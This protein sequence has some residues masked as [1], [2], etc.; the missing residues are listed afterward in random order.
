M[1]LERYPKAVVLDLD[2]TLWPFWCDTHVVRPLKAVSDVV[3]ID[4]C[5]LELSFYEEVESILLELKEYDVKIIGAS[6][7]GTPDIAKDLLTMLHIRGNPA[8]TYFDCLEWGTGSKTRHIQRAAKKLKLTKELANGDFV[9]FDDEKRNRDV[10][11]I[12]CHFIHVPNEGLTRH[13]F[14]QGLRAWNKATK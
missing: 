12:N 11:S 10:S 14:I 7:T 6:R 2:Y 13:T 3:V 5:N 1:V 9:L 4:S 8:I